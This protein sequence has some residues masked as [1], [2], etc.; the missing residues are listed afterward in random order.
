MNRKIIIYYL[1]LIVLFFISIYQIV[2]FQFTKLG[3]WAFLSEIW[4]ILTL[5]LFVWSKKDFTGK[6]WFTIKKKEKIYL[7]EENNSF[8]E[9]DY[10]SALPELNIKEKQAY[11]SL[12]KLC[13]SAEIQGKIIPFLE[14]LKDFSSDKEDYMS[15]LNYVTEFL[16]IHNIFFI[17][18]LDLN[19]DV[20][21]LEW[22]ITT[23]LQNN[24]QDSVELPSISN[25]Q[26]KTVSFDNVCEDF[27]TPLLQAGYQMG[28]IDTESDEYIIVIH[29]VSD[30]EKIEK[31]IDIIGYNYFDTQTDRRLLKPR[32]PF[33]IKYK[34]NSIK[35]IFSLVILILCPAFTFVVYTG[36]LKE[37]LSFIV[38][39]IAIINFLFYY[40]SIY[41]IYDTLRLYIGNRSKTNA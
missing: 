11:I 8:N 16:D 13:C 30:K 39:F 40:L 1:I 33:I 15:T 6:S 25:Y 23:S 31:L 24:F 27:D 5:I 26:K 29:K 10:I 4:A 22:R 35:F 20:E 9:E 32:Y 36:F 38:I 18:P 3:I 2:V 37:G 17:M 19:Q 34:F 7:F 12:T 14:K 41:F 21:T 28:F